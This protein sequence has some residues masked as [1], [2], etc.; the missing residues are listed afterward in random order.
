MATRRETQR[1]PS[2]ATLPGSRPDTSS[3]HEPAE[4]AHAATLRKVRT[5]VEAGRLQDAFDLANRGAADALLKNARGVCLLRMQRPEQ[6]VRVYRE[7]TLTGGGIVIRSNVPLIFKLNFA[8]A[9]LMSGNVGG[10]CEILHEIR[11]E[12]HPR[13]T[14][15]RAAIENWK[16]GL[17][18]FQRLM[19]R[20]GNPPEIPATID[21]V[22]GDFE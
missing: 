14:Q 3:A 19:W 4:S 9:L 16:S 6:A 21:F 11:N 12:D 18:L 10:C 2:P 8:T 15:L 5:L 17:T 1:R 20:L 13:I 7:L 22:P